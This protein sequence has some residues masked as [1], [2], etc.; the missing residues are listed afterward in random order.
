MMSKVRHLFFLLVAT[1]PATAFALSVPPVFVYFGIGNSAPEIDHAIRSVRRAMRDGPRHIRVPLRYV[2]AGHTDRAG[3][4]EA[5]VQLSC[6]RAKAVRDVMVAEGVP[7]EHIELQAFG[8]TRPSVDTDDG[9]TEPM[10]RRVEITYFPRRD[11][12]QPRGRCF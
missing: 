11:S 6:A 1:L 5:N 2:V 12:P 10:N 3:T 7:P 8:E 9:V 4:G